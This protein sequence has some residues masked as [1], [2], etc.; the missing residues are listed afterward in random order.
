MCSRYSLTSPPEAVRALFDLA[1]LDDFP[2]RY[3]IAPSQPVLVVRNAASGGREP[4]L[5]RW[6]LIPSWVKDL[7]KFTTLINARSETVAEKPSFRAA[8]RHRRALVPADVYYEWTATPSGKQPHLIRPPSRAP[9][10]FAGIWENWLGADGSEIETSAIL[11]T[12]A[13]AD[14]SVLHDRM[15]LIIAP[16]DFD[17]WLDCRPGSGAHVL[18]LLQPPPGDGLEIVAVTRKLNNSRLEGAELQTPVA[19]QQPLL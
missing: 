10:A 12:A 9:F 4:V 18:D 15:P 8:F 1:R 2:P 16:K 11:T 5:M 14:L 13:N 3:N 17:R 7:A 6:G 19:A